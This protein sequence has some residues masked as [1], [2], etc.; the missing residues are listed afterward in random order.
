MSVSDVSYVNKSIAYAQSQVEGCEGPLNQELNDLIFGVSLLYDD[1]KEL[2]PK[3]DTTTPSIKKDVTVLKARSSS[4]EVSPKITRVAKRSLAPSHQR[5]HFG[6]PVTRSISRHGSRL[7]ASLHRKRARVEMAPSRRSD[8]LARSRGVGPTGLRGIPNY[9][10]NCFAISSYQLVKSNPSLYNAIF[11]SPTFKADRRFD[12]LREFDRKYDSGAFLSE[13]DMQKVRTN[14]LTQFRIPARGHQDPYE[15]LT[16][17][18]FAHIPASS[19]LYSTIT[20]TRVLEFTVPEDMVDMSIMG[21]DDTRIVSQERMPRNQVKVRI[22]QTLR[23]D[24]MLSL[25]VSLTGIP[26]GAT[27][28]EVIAQ[29]LSEVSGELQRLPSGV[30]ARET[31][32]DFNL[33]VPK[34]LMLTLKRFDSYGNKISDPVSVPNGEIRLDKRGAHQVKGFV[35]HLGESRHSGHY[36]EF[37]KVG[38]QWFL[39]NDEKTTPISTAAAIHA[40]QDAYILYSE[41]P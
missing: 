22:Q 13:A 37:Q 5:M 26:K 2:R 36:V 20:T 10:S 24:P 12:A 39:N 33:N 31:N 27:L 25:P 6:R 15:V 38:D 14:C 23:T 29:D 17:A 1:L 7:P 3:L 34:T 41:R 40:M 35:V 30:N 21:M 4:P 16:N 28:Q 18:L 11:K 19:P 9:A 8:R 32:R